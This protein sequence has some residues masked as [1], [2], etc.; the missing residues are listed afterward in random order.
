MLC[1]C[2]VV[3]VKNVTIKAHLLQPHHW[4]FVLRYY[5]QLLSISYILSLQILLHLLLL[6]IPHNTSRRERTLC[7][8]NHLIPPVCIGACGYGFARGEGRV[9]GQN[10]QRGELTLANRSVLWPHLCTWSLGPQNTVVPVDFNIVWSVRER[11]SSVRDFQNSIRLKTVIYVYV[12]FAKVVFSY[13]PCF[14]VGIVVY[15]SI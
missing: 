14:Q 9:K 12:S 4:D 2:Y 8:R 11:E 15:T 6:S 13:T 3:L 7:S 5:L 10:E 1:Y